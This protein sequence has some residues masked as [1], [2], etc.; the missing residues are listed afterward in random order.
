MSA[1]KNSTTRVGSGSAS[2]SGQVVRPSSPRVPRSASPC[3][4]SPRAAAA[5]SPSALG[6]GSS[7]KSIANKKAERMAAKL[8]K[9]LGVAEKN[10]SFKQPS[11][12]ASFNSDMKVSACAS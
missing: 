9:S 10:P 7:N 6:I 12:E 2:K 11:R 3:P 5:T 1:P 8:N 4:G